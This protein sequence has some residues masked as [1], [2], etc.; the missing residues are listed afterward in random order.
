MYHLKEL[1]KVFEPHPS[2]PKIKCKIFEDNES[3]IVMDMLNN[4]SICTKHTVLKYQHFKIFVEHKIIAIKDFHT[5]E[6]TS[7]TLTKP[8]YNHALFEYL[9]W[10]LCRW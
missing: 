4:F 5:N 8:I 3:C 6:Q 10:N 1:S 9:R 7:D 2:T